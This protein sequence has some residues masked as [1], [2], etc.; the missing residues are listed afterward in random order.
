[1]NQR[2]GLA[3]CPFWGSLDCRLQLP[4]LD[5]PHRAPQAIHDA[6]L[7]GDGR[8][9]S[10]AGQG[11][12]PIVVDGHAVVDSAD[13]ARAVV[14]DWAIAPENWTLP[15]H[16]TMF[17]S[18]FNTTLHA[19]SLSPMGDTYPTLAEVLSDKGYLTAGFVA[20][21]GFLNDEFFGLA[22]GFAHWTDQELSPAMVVASSW[23]TRTI[24]QGVRGAFGVHTDLLQKPA[25]RVNA[26]FM[27]W[28]R[29]V[30]S[31]PYFAF[32]NYFDVHAPYRP[33][34]IPVLP[35][36]NPEPRYWLKRSNR[37]VDGN[38]DVYTANEI[39]D[40]RESYESAIAY[41]DRQLQ[42]L[43]TYLDV[44]GDMQNTLV[45]ITSDHGEQFGEHG[46][47]GHWGRSQ[48]LPVLHVPLMII[49]PRPIPSGIRIAD[50]VSLADLPA[51]ITQLLGITKTPFLG[52]SLARYW[53][54]DSVPG[55]PRPVF[56]GTRDVSVIADG[57]HYIRTRASEA[58][59]YDREELYH[60][61][62]DPEEL[63]DVVPERTEPLVL[64]TMRSLTDSILG[65]RPWR[66]RLSP[67][68]GPWNR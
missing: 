11:R 4:K 60:M 50:P 30:G 3:Y 44:E 25:Q 34:A 38:A 12:V 32:F 49:P 29:R 64:W 8:G 46:R 22:R 39:R 21:L 43:F 45:V 18:R 57:W 53:T 59:S 56:S 24:D 58:T 6:C 1:M 20:N 37:L 9:S 52:A 62:R 66:S 14:F 13:A 33:T 65:S 47:L 63:H 40:L 28:H 27:A 35:T 23:L 31:R 17:T 36:T 67:I 2:G 48:Y 68:T 41:L 10:V 7:D 54:D 42:S 16:A 55:T 5:F 19:R 61:V 26:E 15:S 51:T